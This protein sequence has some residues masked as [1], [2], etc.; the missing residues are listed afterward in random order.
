MYEQH[1]NLLINPYHLSH[2]DYYKMEVDDLIIEI[3]VRGVPTPKIS[4]KRDGVELDI[5]NN[6]DKFFVMR[7]PEGVY[8]LCIHNPQKV[9]SGRFMIEAKNSAG[10]E[11]IRH[12]IR[13][14][15]KDVYSYMPG[16]HH[17]DKKVHEEP[18]EGGVIEE[19]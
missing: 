18:E 17:A 9:D 3:Q 4:W 5:E 7:E 6:P 14:L 19:G 8:K 10:I 16:I 11:E 13:F 12:S 2:L 15:G 1:L